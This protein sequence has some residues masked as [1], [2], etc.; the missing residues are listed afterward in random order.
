MIIN[1]KICQIIRS[2]VK[3]TLTLFVNTESV[4]LNLKNRDKYSTHSIVIL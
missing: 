2:L 3:I 1:G 4:S